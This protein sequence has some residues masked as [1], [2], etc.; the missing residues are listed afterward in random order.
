MDLLVSYALRR[1]QF[2]RRDHVYYHSA[3][4]KESDAFLIICTITSSPQ[5]P[6]QP[7]TTPTQVVPKSFLECIGAL[8]DDPLY[9]DIEFVVPKRSRPKEKRVI[10]ANKKMLQ[11]SDY[12]QSSR[13]F[14]LPPREVYSLVRS[15]RFRLCGSLCGR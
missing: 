11:R 9:S 15:V 8:L 4:V 10:Y 6:I 5:P 14:P 7:P 13:R 3:P 12:F 1:A 2:A